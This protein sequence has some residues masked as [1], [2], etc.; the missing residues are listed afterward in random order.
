MKT[1]EEAYQ[2]LKADFPPEAYSVD[3][4]RGFELT[5]LKAQY[6]VERLNEV[7]GLGGWD[8]TGNYQE[9][10]NGVLFFGALLARVGDQ[11]VEVQN[12]GYAA[13]KRNLGDAYKSSRTDCLSKCASWLGLGNEMY[14][15]NVKPPGK[16]AAK[17]SRSKTKP[18]D[19]NV[20]EIKKAGT[21]RS[22]R[23]GGN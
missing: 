7:F 15:G 6:M 13:A 14:K 23:R 19:S 8:L 20:S 3:D 17:S 16:S 12:V 2:E 18:D 21:M 22:R 5:S 1:L 4:S 10:E 11:G 9:T